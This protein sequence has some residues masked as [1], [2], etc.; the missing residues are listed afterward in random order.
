[1]KIAF[2]VDV[3]D[4]YQT[5]DLNFPVHS[6]QQFQRRVEVNTHQILDLMDQHQARGTFFVL[7]CVAKEFPSLVRQIVSRGH[8]LACHGFWHQMLTRLSPKE[9][10]TDIADAKFL[11][12]HISG[13]PVS[14]YRAPSWSIQPSTYY[15]L[16][17]LEELG[18]AIDSSFQPFKTPLSGIQGAPLEPFHPIIDGRRL[19]ILEVPSCVDTL[20]GM[21]YPFSG[22]LYLRTLPT[23]MIRSAAKRVAKKRPVMLYI[24]PWELD[25]GQPRV[26]RSPVIQFTH[27][28][29]LGTTIAKLRNL[30]SEFRAVPLGELILDMAVPSVELTKGGR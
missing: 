17:I 13:V 29:N 6:W 3:E 8:E 19:S 14:I 12:E 21:R 18:F 11:L 9:V 23:W 20:C 10:R 24:H 22:G 1:M 2:T 16:E 27:Y 28:F 4:W 26:A 5:S 30:L 25:Q 7:G 15:V